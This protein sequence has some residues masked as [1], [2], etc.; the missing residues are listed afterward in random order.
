MFTPHVTLL[1]GI[2]GTQRAVLDTAKDLADELQVSGVKPVNVAAIAD[3]MASVECTM[4][5]NRFIVTGVPVG[6]RCRRNRNWLGVTC[7]A[8]GVTAHR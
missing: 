2:E 6:R 1:G 4:L 8:S 5:E 7:V 3:G